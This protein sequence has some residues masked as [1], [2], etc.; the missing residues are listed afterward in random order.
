VSV[1]VHSANKIAVEKTDSVEFILVE[2]NPNDAE[3]VLRAMRKRYPSSRPTW[4][5]DGAQ[6]LEYL[7]PAD[8]SA[9]SPA[10]QARFMILDLKLPLV[11]GF[12]VLHRIKRDHRTSDLP[13]VILTSSRE[14]ADLDRCTKSG[15]N[16][17]VVKPVGY[18]EFSS[19][20][21]LIGDYWLVL[22]ERA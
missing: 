2:D 15:A 16:S 22:N 17:F 13:V 11:D 20:V 10:N 5:K 19:A 3:M 14:D 6:A 8:E 4:L 7:L 1:L 21:G 18:D 12:E 9:A